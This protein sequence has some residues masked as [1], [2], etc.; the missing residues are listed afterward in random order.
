MSS[1][2]VQQSNNTISAAVL[3][4]PSNKE[5]KQ[6][7]VALVKKPNK[8]IEKLNKA[9]TASLPPNVEGGPFGSLFIEMGQMEWFTYDNVNYLADSGGEFRPI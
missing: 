1:S 2:N 6:G 3:T 8:A 5:A 4:Q 7:E 9:S